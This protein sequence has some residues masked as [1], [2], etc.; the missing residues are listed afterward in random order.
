KFDFK[1]ANVQTVHNELIKD[2]RFVLVGRGLYALAEW[3]FEPGTVKDVL[4][5]LLKKHGPMSKEE[6]IAKTAAVRFV[7]PNTIVL[8]LQDRKYFQKDGKG[9]Y[10]LVKEA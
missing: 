3:G 9:F 5:G 1:K 2:K 8:N 6:I 7:K 4:V 10:K